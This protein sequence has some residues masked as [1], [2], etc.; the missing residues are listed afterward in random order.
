MSS[1]VPRIAS[2][3]F[4][5]DCLIDDVTGPL[6]YSGSDVVVNR[7]AAGESAAGRR[8]KSRA[9]GSEMM[10]HAVIRRRTAGIARRTFLEC[11]ALRGTCNNRSIVE[12]LMARIF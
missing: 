2:R 12:A 4:V 3:N 10:T 8:Q 7:N 6:P 1:R 9:D 11:V 5:T